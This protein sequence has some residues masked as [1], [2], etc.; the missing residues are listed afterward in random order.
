MDIV[1]DYLFHIQHHDPA[2]SIVIGDM[3]LA[4]TAFALVT[5][6]AAVMRLLIS[7]LVGS[8]AQSAPNQ[9]G[10]I[11]IRI[12][13]TT[14]GGTN[15]VLDI[16]LDGTPSDGGGVSLTGSQVSFGTASQPQQYTGQ[17]TD[18]RGGVLQISTRDSSG[19]RLALS[20]T[21]NLNGARV[22]GQLSASSGSQQ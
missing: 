17:L 20:V 10:E 14:G 6:A 16:V 3:N 11:A 18:L 7:P 8:V 13:A 4:A 12:H 19:R 5:S 22:T 1:W 9:N 2:K 21:V 15:G